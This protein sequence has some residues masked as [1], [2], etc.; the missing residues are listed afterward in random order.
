MIGV[1]SS[2]IEI[3]LIF[4]GKMSLFGSITTNVVVMLDVIILESV[5]L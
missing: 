2:F 5:N 4:C 3:I 1:I